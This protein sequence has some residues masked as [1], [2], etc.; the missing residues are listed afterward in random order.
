MRFTSCLVHLLPVLTL[1]APGVAAGTTH[2]DT[3]RTRAAAIDAHV[4]RLGKLGF[5]G[6]FVLEVGGTVLVERGCGLADREAA[7]AWSTAIVSDIGSI[8]KQFTAAAILRLQEQGHLQVQDGLGKHIAGVPPD[9]AGITLHHLLTHTSGVQDVPD[10]DDWDPVDR[11]EIVRLTMSAPLATP[12]GTH[13]AYSNAGYSLLGVAIEN[14][15]GTSY[16]AA[17]RALLFAPAGMQHTGYMEPEWDAH[18]I[19]AGYL[20]GKRWGTTL[21]RPF[22]S[23][24][25]YWIL[26]ANGGLHSTAPDMLRWARA[27]MDNSVLGA[28][29]RQALWS[30]HVDESNGR[31]ESYYGY[32]WTVIDLP[33]GRTAVK[34]NGG[35]GIHYADFAIEPV[36]RIVVFLMTNVVSEF[37]VQQLLDDVG[38]FLFTGAPLPEVPDAQPLGDVSSLLGT[39]VVSEAASSATAATAAVFSVQVDGD[40]LAIETS[41]WRDFSRVYGA[42]PGDL[43]RLEAQS[44]SV[45]A[46]VTAMLR[47]DYAPLHAAYGGRVPIET[48]R[49]RGEARLRAD[50]DR[51]GELRAHRTLG[52]LITHEGSMTFVRFEHERGVHHRRYVWSMDGTLRGLSGRR[53]APPRFHRTPQGAFVSFEI[54]TP[55]TRLVFSDADG[56]VL[57]RFGPPEASYAARKN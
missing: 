49:E 47:G 52:T 11:D 31:G 35:N 24:G 29:S 17:L 51:F 2:P 37:P 22:A 18:D 26:R 48:L 39:Y 45:D 9:K 20:D 38:R 23:D 44:R 41:T 5:A 14:I 19:A 40:A 54:G 28:A 3:L 33:D 13:Y 27:L 56:G 6:V 43:D 4:A 12:P 25:P 16:E 57:L 7:K 42:A 55:A 53:Q 32:G 21:E 1:G 46:L 30:K 34:H 50:A 8:T 15:T 36:E 10:R